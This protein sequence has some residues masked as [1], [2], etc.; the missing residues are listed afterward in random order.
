[1][2]KYPAL[3]PTRGNVKWTIAKVAYLIHVR[4]IALNELG[5]FL[6]YDK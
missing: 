5:K 6:V 1:M 3:S 4:Q 2:S